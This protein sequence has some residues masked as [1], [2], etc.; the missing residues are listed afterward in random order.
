MQSQ[1]R[2]FD[3]SKHILSIFEGFEIHQKKKNKKITEDSQI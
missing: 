3:T 2:N 1:I